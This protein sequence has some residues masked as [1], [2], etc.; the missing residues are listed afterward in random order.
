[1]GEVE[2]EIEGV[3]YEEEQEGSNKQRGS[4]VHGFFFF[5]LTHLLF[6]S[7]R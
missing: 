7:L 5:S 3:K 4:F 2:R 6:L 1:M